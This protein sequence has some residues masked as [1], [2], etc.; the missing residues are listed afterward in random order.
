M[1]RIAFSLW[2]VLCLFSPRE[3]IAQGSEARYGREVLPG[4]M[5]LTGAGLQPFQTRFDVP[6][7]ADPYISFSETGV[8]MTGTAQFSMHFKSL[9]DLRRGGPYRIDSRKFYYSDGSPME[10]GAPSW[11]MKP[12]YWSQTGNG[13]LRLWNPSVDPTPHLTVWYGGHM[14]PPVHKRVA[15]WPADNFSRDVF[16]F[17]ERTPGKWIS[18][19]DSVFSGRN[20]WPRAAGNY[21]GHRYGH[22]IVMIQKPH[23]R[24][25]S[26]VPG[27]FYE[28]VT[29]I[30]ENGGPAVT[31]I[32]V[33]EMISPFKA[34]GK[35]QELISPFR[36]DGRPYPSAVREDGSVLVEGPLYFR[37]K[38]SGEAWEAIGF[39]AGSFYGKYSACFAYRKVSDG[40]LGKPFQPDLT[41]DGLHDSGAELGRILN[42]AGG[43]GR[44]AVIVDAE[45]LAVP[46]EQGALQV[47]FHGY[48]KEILPDNDYTRFPVKYRLDQ[49]YR[50]AMIA[51]LKITKRRKGAL[52]FVL[53]PVQ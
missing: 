14:R 12:S 52:R 2:T 39:S 31:R 19:A 45:G 34:K 8:L 47:L 7:L 13:G 33:D 15:N 16:V 36:P 23:T 49:M 51:T 30:R 28:E 37:F 41:D 32:F 4:V 46:D 24:K 21:L 18:E 43:P 38:L 10:G 9:A 3:Q 5:M 6:E 42:L 17:I 20:Q 22:Q 50:S 48:R 27:I 25:P 53:A 26:R 29:D 44:P 1:R 35:P 11:D 40:I